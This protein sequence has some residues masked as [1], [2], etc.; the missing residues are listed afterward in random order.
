MG[1]DIKK[2]LNGIMCEDVEWIQLVQN[3][4]QWRAIMN[5]VMALRLP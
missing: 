2:D 4:V 5:T 3:T 1:Y